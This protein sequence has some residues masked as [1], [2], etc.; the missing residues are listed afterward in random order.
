M[1]RHEGKASRTDRQGLADAEGE[2]VDGTAVHDGERAAALIGR[3]PGRPAD[4]AG[5]VAAAG[6][7]VTVV[8]AGMERLQDARDVRQGSAVGGRLGA[9]RVRGRAQD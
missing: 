1:K 6:A 3:V 5:A 8:V 2:D 9:L 4:G 7:E